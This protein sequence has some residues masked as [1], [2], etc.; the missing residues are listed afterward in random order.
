[1]SEE[2]VEIVREAFE[3]FASTGK[4]AEEFTTDD[5]VW[6]MSN[7]HGWPEQQTYEGADGV[8]AFMSEWVSAWEDWEIHQEKLHEAG[9][10]VVALMR[11]SGRSKAGGAPIEMSFAMV[12][13]L[14]DGKES[15]MDMYS[16]RAEALAAAGLQAQP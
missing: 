3:R 2:N 5:F 9:D 12:F 1:M 10:K 6:D 7:Y 13:T 11:Q 8:D 14:R 16:D 15:R 4:F